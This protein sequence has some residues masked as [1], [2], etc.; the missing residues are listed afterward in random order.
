MQNLMQ[1][2]RFSVR[3]LLSTPVVTAA[4]L[5]SLALAVGAN[6][7]IVGAVRGLL[8]TPLPFQE[9]NSLVNI[10]ATYPDRPEAQFSNSYPNYVDFRE[11]PALEGLAASQGTSHTVVAESEPFRV[12]GLTSTDNLFRILS[13]DPVLGRT[14][15][16]GEAGVG[17]D[18]V[19]VLSHRLWQD[20][21]N[22][23][24]EVLGRS[25]L[26]D[27]D[28][29]TVVGVM[30]EGFFYPYEEIALWTPLLRDKS[31]WSRVNGGLQLVGRVAPGSSV[32]Q[33]QVQTSEVARRFSGEHPGTWLEDMTTMVMTVPQ[34]LYGEGV[35]LR[36]YALWGAVGLL[37][38][39][40]CINVANLLLA[41]STSRRREVAVRS[42]LGAGKGRITALFLTESL[43]LGLGSGLI[44]VGVA[45]AGVRLLRWAA[46]AD[47]VRAAELTLDPWVMVFTVLLG[48]LTGVFFG[49]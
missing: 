46:L 34:A 16:E 35:S 6:G 31:N 10:W 22:G 28:P 42:A 49:I 40:A 21:F 26:L 15:L 12:E 7:A 9:P 25:F 47:A 2:L 24:R 48:T 19:A 29:Y 11:V 43:T 8:M 33:I 44:G 4:A 41:R 32:E 38:L 30:P 3:R 17:G 14:F 23:D 13:V 27:G 20:R 18:R 39:I 1:D 37:L 45:W 5:L 36:L